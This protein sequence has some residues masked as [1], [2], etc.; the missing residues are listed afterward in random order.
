LSNQKKKI[1]KCLFYI[2]SKFFSDEIISDCVGK[3]GFGKIY[4]CIDST[5]NNNSTN[6]TLNG[7]KRK[8]VIKEMELGNGETTIRKEKEIGLLTKFNNPCLVQYNDVFT[9]GN[10]V[11]AVMP[12]FEKGDLRKYISTFKIENRK[13]PNE[14]FIM[15]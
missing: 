4:L 3:G 1:G 2:I 13:I 12:Y 9:I 8:L 7:E 14:V 10:K 5:L 6:L 11:Y 15:I